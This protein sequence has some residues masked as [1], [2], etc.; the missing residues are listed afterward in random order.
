MKTLRITAVLS[1]LLLLSC[2]VLSGCA[3]RDEALS[4][5]FSDMSWDSTLENI[6][7]AEGDNYETHDSI[8]DGITYSFPKNYA[9]ESGTVKYMFDGDD[10]L[11][12]IAWSCET[13]D[14]DELNRIYDSIRSD[15]ENTYGDSDYSTDEASNHGNVWRFEEGNIILGAVTTDSVCTLQYSYLHPDVSSKGK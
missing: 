2:T 11:M 5:P 14:A 8:Y 6:T 1:S 3:G 13:D 10:R 7:A 4:I 12:C 9:G 15:L